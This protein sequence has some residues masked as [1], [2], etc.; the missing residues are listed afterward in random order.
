MNRPSHVWSQLL[1]SALLYT[2]LASP[3]LARADES[4]ALAAPAPPTASDEP[5]SVDLPPL[6]VTGRRTEQKLFEVDRNLQRVDHSDVRKLQ[7]QSMPDALKETTGVHMQ[8]TH[9]GAGAPYLRGLVGPQNLLVI[10]GIRF[11]NSTFRTGPNQYLSMLDPSSFARMEV[12]LG[13]GSVLYGADALGGVLQFFPADFVHEQ[14]FG[15]RGGL[16]FASADLS[17]SGWADASWRND[18]FGVLAGGAL[19]NF[20]TLTAGGGVE[21]PL[22]DYQQGAWHLRARYQPT[23]TLTLD[24]TWLGAR[25]NDAMRLDEVRRL[26]SGINRIR[27]YDNQD[28]IGWLD[29][30]WRPKRMAL[31]E[32]RLAGALH[33]THET[34]YQVRCTMDAALAGMSDCIDAVDTWRDAPTAQPGT[35]IARQDEATDTVLTP[36]GLV[37][38]HF[39]F[40]NKRIRSVVG[41]D[42]W[43]D[44]V[45]SSK[46]ERRADKN[47]WAWKDL[48]RGNFSDG[49]AY[50]TGG[51]FAH[52]DADVAKWGAKSVVAGAGARLTHVTASA[53]DVPS[54]GD[55]DYD[56]TGAVATA[57]LKYLH[58]ETFMLY[59]NFAQ[60]FRAPNLQESTVLGNTGSKFEIPNANL[61][62]ET[63]NTV[64][65][66][67]R[68]Q[69]GAVALHLAG[70][71]SWLQ[72]V[73]D[74]RTVPEA[75]WKAMGIAADDVG[76]TPVIQRVNSTK[77]LFKGAELTL[78]GGPWWQVTPWAR[79][80]WVEGDLTDAAGLESP[81][82]RIPPAL[83]SAGVRYALPRDRGYVEVFSRF[84]AAQD[85]LHAS[86]END[87]R[88]CED[89]AHPGK[90]YKEGG[91]QC[92]GTPAWATVNL[93]AGYR[94]EDLHIDAALTNLTDAA[95]RLHGSGVNEAGIGASVSMTAEY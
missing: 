56:H 57:D 23:D 34:S 65:L 75:E 84:A 2:L 64:E 12:L 59:G 60:G 50:A 8:S 33:R 27:R 91:G 58:G 79:A 16:R 63:S 28:D 54:I 20:G 77:G 61:K 24:L 39:D 3:S 7:A 62:P 83:G 13:P 78:Q 73:I 80:S 4:Q 15:A 6:V 92:P 5:P 71:V 35:P 19:R 94:W 90:T 26:S 36:G 40:W 66:G 74:E 93:R 70:F 30:R 48:T 81:A 41:A 72:D 52:A 67:G 11:S 76:T 25:L 21:Q 45:D 17:T 53:Q 47:D 9:R 32:L 38:A 37:E 44:A 31:R 1:S 22:S 55:V 89:P 87:L 95:Y 29:A 51:A 49:S 82:R 46:R 85:R 86:D 88:I 69:A 18:S 14:G 68:V 10:D 43:F 42:A